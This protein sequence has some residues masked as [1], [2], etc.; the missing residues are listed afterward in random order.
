VPHPLALQEG[1]RDGGEYD[2]M[3]PA[4]IAALGRRNAAT[5]VVNQLC[6]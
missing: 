1:V 2:V 4:R 3:M 5:I 6:P